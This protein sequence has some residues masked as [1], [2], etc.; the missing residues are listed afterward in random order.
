MN[1]E[2]VAGIKTRKTAIMDS[3]KSY[4][5]VQLIPIT[6]L[7]LIIIIAAFV[8]PVFLTG[9]NVQNLVV[10]VSTTMIVSMSMLMV[11]FQSK[12]R[13]ST[14]APDIILTPL[15]RSVLRR[16]YKAG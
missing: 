5:K 3:L 16:L 2:N 11:I 1:N 12:P 7:L 8:S 6:V 9:P 4:F 15:G 10:Q 13:L 14:G